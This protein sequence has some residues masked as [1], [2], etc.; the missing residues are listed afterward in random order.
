MWKSFYALWNYHDMK[1][2]SFC[3]DIDALLVANQMNVSLLDHCYIVL[4][5]YIFAKRSKL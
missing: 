1:M 5:P 4:K 2:H 3:D